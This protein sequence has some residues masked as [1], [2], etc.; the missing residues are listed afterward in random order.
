[1]KHVMYLSM[2]VIVCAIPLGVA[3]AGE[4]VATL[5]P[6]IDVTTW[7][8]APFRWKDVDDN[9]YAQSYMDSFLYETPIVTLTYSD[10]GPRFEGTLQG[11]GLKP[12]FAYQM[13][14][15]G[16]PETDTVWGNNADDWSNEQVGYTGRWWRKQPNPGNSNDADYEAHHDDPGYIFQGYLLFDYFVTDESGS[17]TK[18]F[19]LDSSFHVLWKTSQRSPHANDSDTTTHVVD[20]FLP[21]AYD[22][23][24]ESDTVSLYAEWES[25]RA[26]PG[27]ATLPYGTYNVSFVLTEES[28]HQS[29]LGGYWAAAMCHDTVRF[30][31]VEASN[32]GELVPSVLPKRAAL[33]KNHPNP[34]S[35][36]TTI[37]YELAKA[38]EVELAV[39]DIEGRLVR[40]PVKGHREPGRYCADCDL[41]SLPSGL[42]FCSLRTGDF[43]CAKKLLLLE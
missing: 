8:D 26:L 32:V 28:F 22:H 14:L 31:L 6:A 21:P 9:L 20:T 37:G 43:R 19:S 34:F 10:I 33:L 36:S 7:P 38:G 39:F 40:T 15:V 23:T 24:Y 11:Q 13:K 12:N 25:G 42:Y 30:S 17:I 18:D 27:E 5:Y 41:S 4:A 2:A 35:Q 29:G 16:K 3:E 1:M